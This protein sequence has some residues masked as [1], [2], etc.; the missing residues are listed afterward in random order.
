MK[1]IFFVIACTLVTITFANAQGKSTVAKDKNAGLTNEQ[2]ATKRVD[3]FIKK[4][5]FPS[6]LKEKL[7]PI[8]LDR[9]QV[10][11]KAKSAE[12]KESKAI[13]AANAKF[14]TQL[15]QVLSADQFATVKKAWEEKKEKLKKAKGKG[16]KIEDGDELED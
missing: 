5:A 13:S 8:F 7:Y 2:L 4:F 1:N 11:R 15:Q 16:K 14:K 10:V 3:G 6:D 9:I 12:V